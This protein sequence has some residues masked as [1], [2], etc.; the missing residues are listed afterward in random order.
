MRRLALVVSLVIGCGGGSEPEYGVAT[1]LIGRDWSVPPGQELYKCIGIQ[2]DRDMFIH[3]FST[4]NPPGEH[5]TLLTVT[6][7]L[8]GIGGTQLGEY[9]CSVLTVDLQMLYA[10]GV[11]TDTLVMPEGVALHVR[12]GQFLHLNLH[13]FNT[14]D[15]VIATRSSILATE[16]PPVPPEREAEMLFA[17]TFAINVPAGQTGT[18]GGG[19][20]FRRDGTLFAYWPHMHQFANHQKVTMMLGGQPR[21]I[22]DEPW[23]FGEQTNVPFDPPLEVHEGDSIRVDCTYTNTLGTTLQWGDS[24]TE[25]MCFTGLYRYPK[26]ATTLFDCTENED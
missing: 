17:G 25:E 23:I 21:T 18:T 26:Q 3:E 11:G 2:V 24:S 8:G 9:D 13:L 10:S 14:T 16:I 22:H 5:H 6:D 7:E 12:A 15:A 19:C 4:L 20:T 1:E